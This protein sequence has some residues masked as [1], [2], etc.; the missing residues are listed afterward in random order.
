MI[1]FRNRESVAI[2]GLRKGKVK[3]VGGLALA[4][5][6]RSYSGRIR[7]A[8]KG[9][10]DNWGIGIEGSF[11]GSTAKLVS[12]GGLCFRDNEKSLSEI[13]SPMARN[14]YNNNFR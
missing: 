9:F 3:D 7:D 11:F 12:V 1:H 8:C 2:G 13:V 6:L 4:E 10:L 14:V 5:R